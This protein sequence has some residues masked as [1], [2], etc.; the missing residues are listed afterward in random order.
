MKPTALVTEKIE[1]RNSRNGRMGSAA[2]RSCTMN[3]DNNTTAV[4]PKPMMGTE[5]HAYSLPPHTITN[6]A[7]VTE[8]TSRPA[9]T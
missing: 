9:P 8:P 4:A 7:L 5:A 1:L 2:R 6:S 3:N